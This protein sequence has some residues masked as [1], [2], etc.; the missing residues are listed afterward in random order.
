[1]IPLQIQFFRAF[2]AGWLWNS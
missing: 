1:M 2:R